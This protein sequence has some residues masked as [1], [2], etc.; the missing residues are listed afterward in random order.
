MD[1]ASQFYDIGIGNE[2][3]SKIQTGG[4]SELSIQNPL[5]LKSGFKNSIVL[6]VLL[7]FPF[8]GSAQNILPSNEE[9]VVIDTKL[10]SPQIA[11][12]VSAVVPGLGH[13]YVDK[14]N[15]NRGKIHLATDVVLMLG[16]LGLHIR[17]D[18]LEGNLNALARSKAGT[19]LSGKNRAYELAVSGFNSLEEYNDFQLRS[20]NWNNLIPNTPEN[21]W[22]WNSTEDRLAFSD[23]RDRLAQS[24]NQLPTVLVVMFAN[25]VFS[26]VNAF[27]RARNMRVTP[28]VGFSYLNEMGEPGL[29][30]RLRLDF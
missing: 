16:Y 22:Q 6:T 18:Q 8:F 27:T 5:D 21:Q 23:T 7:L 1:L 19:S 26:G 12:I 9:S 20:R 14:T 30:A 3:K 13:Y 25:R 28:E 29:T 17:V 24:E 4:D 10:P 15:W 11:F 2:R